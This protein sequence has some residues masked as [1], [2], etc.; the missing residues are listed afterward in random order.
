MMRHI[1]KSVWNHAAC[2]LL[3]LTLACGGCAYLRP[4]ET[5]DG[6]PVYEVRKADWT[7]E[8]KGRW[9]SP[10]WKHANTLEV[11]NF[12][13]QTPEGL[14]ASD[15]RPVT[16]AR[17]LYDDK[18]LYIHFR[19]K[20]QYVRSVATEYHGR[21]WEDACV[22]FFVQPKADRGYFNFEINCGGTMLLSYHENPNWQGETKRE[23]GAVPKGLARGVKIHHSMPKV[24]EP[25][26]EGRVTWQVEYFIPF[27]LL[28]EYTGP[29]GGVAG[30]EWRANFYKIAE[31]NS[32]PHL[33]SWSPI[34]EGYSFH[35][36]EFF[37]TIRFE[38]QRGCW[39]RSL[40]PRHREDK[41]TA[42][43]AIDKGTE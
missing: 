36:P 8:L 15:H 4:P 39:L 19:V 42:E 34:L 3:A 41:A 5:I 18:G 31:T 27:W 35:Q 17:V 13:P 22:E 32:H 16:K 1:A 38:Q 28:E 37:G 20:D 2:L 43:P 12:L 29:L 11:A 9:R 33:A 24:V 23:G 6:R 40:C 26:I 25:E 21:V 30:Q 7:P 10:A 14:A